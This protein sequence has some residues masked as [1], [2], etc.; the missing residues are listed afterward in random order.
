MAVHLLDDAVEKAVDGAAFMHAHMV[1]VERVGKGDAPALGEAVLFGRH[2]HQSVGAEMDELQ[3]FGF[4]I[5]GHDADVGAAVAHRAHDLGIGAFL[6]IH[7]HVGVLGQK[8][9]EHFGHEV[10]H[11]GGV[12]KHA[13]MAAQAAAVFVEVA[14]QALGLLQHDAC[15]VQKRFAGRGEAHAA[16]F[17]VKQLQLGLV[18]ER[19]DARARGRE[20]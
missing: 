5:A 19:F 18:F 4:D 13:H 20:R 14:L 7:I 11:G 9:R 6:Q 17:A 12:G 8:A 2:E 15:M 16:R 1:F 10:G 3:A